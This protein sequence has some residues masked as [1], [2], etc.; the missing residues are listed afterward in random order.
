[1]NDGHEEKSICIFKTNYWHLL[2]FLKNLQNEFLNKYIKVIV[3]C[4][5]RSWDKNFQKYNSQK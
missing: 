2:N 5:W 1:M 4:I 3:L